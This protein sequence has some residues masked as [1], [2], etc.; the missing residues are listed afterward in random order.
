MF[1]ISDIASLPL[2]Y[3]VFCI[4][5]GNLASKSM[6]FQGLLDTGSQCSIL[7]Q[8]TVDESDMGEQMKNC[9]ANITLRGATGAQKE[10]FVGQIRLIMQLLTSNNRL[11]QPVSH[12]FF[13]STSRRQNIFGSDFISNVKGKICF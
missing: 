8:K 9:E 7:T 13:V 11:S 10:P 2:P 5:S 3:I 1:S 12:E 4:S 6:F